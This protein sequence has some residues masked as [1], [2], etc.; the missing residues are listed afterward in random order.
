MRSSVVRLSLIFLG[1]FAAL[2]LVGA[3][4]AA[5]APAALNVAMATDVGSIEFT[6]PPE[7]SADLSAKASVGD[8]STNRPLTVRGSLARHS[9]RA[10]LGKGEGRVNLDTNVGSIRIQ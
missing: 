6:G 5:D 10:S 3:T 1:V 2:T 9:V 4:Y 8:I 7:I